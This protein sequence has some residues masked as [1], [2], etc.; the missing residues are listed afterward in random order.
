MLTFS[1]SSIS[2]M[3]AGFAEPEGDGFPVVT[4]VIVSAAIAA[5]AAV[6][7]VFLFRRE[8]KV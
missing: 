4:L 3:A 1:T 6:S 7:A 2:Y 5:V 8:R